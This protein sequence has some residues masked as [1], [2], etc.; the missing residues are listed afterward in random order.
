M[1]GKK[2]SSSFIPTGL[3][4]NYYPLNFIITDKNGNKILPNS[5]V[6]KDNLRGEIKK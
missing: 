3:N 2:D 6:Q 4:Q 1:P 5:Q